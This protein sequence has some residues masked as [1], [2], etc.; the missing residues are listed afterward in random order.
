MITKL[1]SILL[2]IHLF[3]ISS[4]AQE[5]NFGTYS[6][7]YSV[8]LD[9]FSPGTNLEFGTVVQETSASIDI[10]SS[11]IFTITGVEYL[12]VLVEVTAD[13]YLLLDGLI[14]CE[15]NPA[16]RIPFTLQSSYANQGQNLTSQSINMMVLG[17]VASA[18]F[19]LKYRGSGPP[20]PPPTPVYE[21]YNPAVF[22][23]T[24]YLYIYGSINVGTV[25][26]GNY[27]GNI[28][29]MVSYD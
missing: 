13:Q 4:I 15:T 27:T 19:P 8:S 7:L 16:C 11:K 12:D 20:G 25:D 14:G 26:A 28:N 18:Q 9:E 6:S 29:I 3:S 21:G 5:I 24:A 10:N 23:D 2:L 22:N 17:S 1:I